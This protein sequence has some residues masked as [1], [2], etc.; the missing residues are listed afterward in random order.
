M[1]FSRYIANRILNSGQEKNNISSPIVKIGITGIA[2]GVAGIFEN[3]NG[4]DSPLNEE[5]IHIKNFLSHKF[6]YIPQ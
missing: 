1:N 5:E 3:K 4:E 2:L 6:A